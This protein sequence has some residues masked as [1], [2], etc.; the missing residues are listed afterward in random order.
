[1]LKRFIPMLAASVAIFVVASPASAAVEIVSA[2]SIQG[3][4]VHGTNNEQ[5]ALDVSGL[6]GAN[7]PQIVH[8]AGDTTQTAATSDLLRLQ[9]GGGQADVTGAE[10]TLGG[11]PN[12]A[13]EILSGNIFLSPG[14]TIN[15]IEFALTSGAVGSVDFFIT[16]GDGGVT[17]FLN[18]VIGNGDTFFAFDTTGLTTIT[19][20]RYVAD[21]PPTSFSLL[22]QVRLD[23][24]VGS[25]VPEPGTW[26]MMLLGFGAVGAGMRRRR[27]AV[28]QAA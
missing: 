4:L 8:F 27:R 22:K 5:T 3:T 19:N 16:D 7:G 14:Y 6:L 26:A 28:L 12:D 18:Q 9:D 2:S 23:V 15:S 17:S 24:N 20:V 21:A 10:I 1:M 13:Y 11:T 25:P